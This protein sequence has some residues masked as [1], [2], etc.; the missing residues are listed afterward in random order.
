M[1]PLVLGKPTQ[2]LGSVSVHLVGLAQVHAAQHD[3]QLL[4]LGPAGDD[5]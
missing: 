5:L 1:S 3:D 2:E 4:I